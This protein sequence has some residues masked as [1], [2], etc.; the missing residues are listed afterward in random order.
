MKNFK[1]RMNDAFRQLSTLKES[2]DTTNFGR[3]NL[4]LWNRV[5][6]EIWLD[7]TRENNVNRND[8]QTFGKFGQFFF[9]YWSEYQKLPTQ[10][11]VA[12]YLRS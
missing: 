5:Q 10:E 1:V 11:E 7:Y 6:Y 8:A 9:S 2:I 12:K 3:H 4:A